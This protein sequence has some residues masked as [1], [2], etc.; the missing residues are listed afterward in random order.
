MFMKKMN[1]QIPKG[2]TWV[3]LFLDN[4]TIFSIK[5]F[6]SHLRIFIANQMTQ[7]GI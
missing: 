2:E 6:S 7:K 4:R 1:G 5:I 3:I